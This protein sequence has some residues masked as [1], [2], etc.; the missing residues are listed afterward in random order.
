MLKFKFNKNKDEGLS[1]I[2]V[3][4]SLSF[5][6]LGL[7][8]LFGI[9]VSSINLSTRIK[10]NLIAAN[11]AQ[12]GIEVVR[13]MRDKAWMDDAAYDRDLTPGDSLVSWDS[14]VLTAYDPTVY[15][16]VDPNTGIY[17][18]T[19]GIDTIFK[20]RINITKIPSSC[21]CEVGVVSDVTWIEK[22]Q[23][24]EILVESHLLNWGQ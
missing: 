5:L 17:S 6:S 8:P 20:R 1:L 9:I 21:N 15:M 24:K 2:E 19:G 11:L 4:V 16:K 22:N 14:N 12:E 10:N 23:T 18:Q 13:A 3:L 7:I